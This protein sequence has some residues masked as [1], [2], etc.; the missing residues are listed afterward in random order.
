MGDNEQCWTCEV[1]DDEVL[2]AMGPDRDE[3]RT[4]KMNDPKEPTPE[5]RL[6][7]E[8]THLPYRSW[9]QHCVKGRGKEMP[10][11][12]QEEA[13]GLP[14]VHFDYAFMGDEGDPGGTVPMLVA[15]SRQDRMTLATAVPR[16]STGEFVVNRVMAFLKEVGLEAADVVVKSDQEPAIMS[17]VEE[18][19]RKKAAHGG[20]WVMEASPVGSHASNGAVERAIQSVEGQVRVLKDALETR[21]GVKIKAA[22]AVIPWIM[23]YAAYL[24]SRFEV[25]HDGKTAFERCKGKK[26]KVL[27][28]E[29]GEAILW[30]RKPVGGALGKLSVMWADG[31]FL[32]MKGRTG[33]CI[34]GDQTGVW[35][36]RTAQRKPEA[37]R[38][39]SGYAE[40]IKWVPWKVSE[41]DVKADGESYEVLRPEAGDV[42]EPGLGRMAGAVPRKAKIRRE[43]LMTHGFTAGCEGCKAILAG[44]TARA[45]SAKCRGR[46]EDLLK[47]EPRMKD[48]KERANE[49]LSKVLEEEDKKRAKLMENQE[50]QDKVGA[51]EKDREKDTRMEDGALEARL[52]QSASAGSSGCN[53]TERKMQVEGD[54]RLGMEQSTAMATDAGSSR[55]DRRG[56]DGGDDGSGAKKMMK[57]GDGAMAVEDRQGEKRKTEG[58]GDEEREREDR[59]DLQDMDMVEVDEEENPI[60]EW[61]GDE[62]YTDQ[63][64]G[65]DIDPEL[66]KAARAEEVRF[67]EKI[68]LYDEVPIRE[69]WE[70][71]GSPPVSTKWVDI[72][73]GSAEK[74]DIRCRLVARDF[75]PKGEKDRI[76][77]FAATPPLEAKKF[78]FQHAVQENWRRRRARRPGIKVMFI[79]VKKA[80][81]NGVL[82]ED[83]RAYIELPGDAGQRG[84]CGRLKRWLYGMRPAAGAWED[85]Y[86]ERLAEIGFRKG[87]AAPTAFYREADE[88]RCVVHG[89]DF[90]FTGEL[91]ALRQIARDMEKS[92]ELKVRGILG[93]EA[94]DDKRITILSRVVEWVQ[95]GIRYVADPRHAEEIVQHFGLDGSSKGLDVPIIKEDEMGI[96]PGED[97]VGEGLRE[98]RGLAARANYLS[99]DRVDV[100]Y[101][102]KEI[103]RDMAKPNDRSMAKL[104]RL[105]RYLLKYPEGAIM[106]KPNRHEERGNV[107]DVYSDSDWAGCTRTRKSTSGGL[108]RYCGGGI[109]KSWS[110]TQ[111]TVALSSGEAEYYAVVKAAA[112]GLGVMALMADLGIEGRVRL[113]VDSSAAK[114]ISSRVG[115]GKLR[116][117]EVKYLWVQQLVK[118]KRIT[119][120]KVR[121][122]FNP[123][124]WLTKPGST[125]QRRE[126]FERNDYFV[127]SLHA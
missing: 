60:N 64:T 81:L 55:Q 112:E 18:V 107:L 35:K 125:T 108:A 24:L 37:M 78:L 13:G 122:E 8:K 32:G 75:K 63:K 11:R 25:G 9:C 1:G 76:D 72:N 48:A 90:T 12:R 62:A 127:K 97:L 31:V 22:N 7:H 16:K 26:A 61:D 23:E 19:G 56:I 86:S 98:F 68:G 41:D 113:W 44:T 118:K 40:W 95:E 96:G 92:Y 50:G 21:W 100:Q 20:R 104:K 116:H 3:R 70:E 109:L 51:Q 30:R 14:E 57:T 117:L 71:T 115:L 36:T 4:M 77:L 84:V 65:G 74:P 33:E 45:H 2:E 66:A 53:E 102:A 114:S 6:E 47:D 38:W 28:L 85:D 124:D 46:M 42:P 121:G 52:P 79:D 101:A 69:C 93:D 110:S 120:H 88:V 87:A 105:A 43:D 126:A 54:L 99:A 80:H 5:E 111:A 82:K 58:G 94:G 39:K 67:M 27:G 119:I 34:V 49:F 15:R 123:A 89:D 83:E 59:E 17:L 10:H 106:F 91:E 103:C 29:F 73:K